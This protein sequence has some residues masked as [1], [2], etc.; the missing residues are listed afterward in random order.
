VT[1]RAVTIDPEYGD[2]Y[3]RFLWRHADGSAALWSMTS[4]G[5]LSR[6]S[7]HGPHPGWTVID[8]A[9]GPE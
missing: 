9:A 1:R 7:A 3:S 2:I 4:A 5:A 8:V 6:S